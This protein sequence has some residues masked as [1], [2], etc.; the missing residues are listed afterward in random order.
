MNLNFTSGSSID[1]TFA[2]GQLLLTGT[3]TQD[4]HVVN[5]AYVDAYVNGLDFK[6]SVRVATT[7]NITLENEQT[8]DGVSVVAGDRVLVKDQ[9]SGSQ[10]G[11]Y[12]V[13]DGG[14]W[15]RATD[16]DENTEV[17]AGMY[18]YV[19][20]GTANSGKAYVL[21]TTGAI[22]LGTTALTFQLFP[23]VVT[24]SAG[25]GLT[26]VGD[27]LDVNYDDVTINLTGNDLQVKDGGINQ[28]KI[29]SSALGNGL[30]GGSGTAIAVLA[31]PTAANISI[32]GTG[33]KLAVLSDNHFFYSDG[34]NMVSVNYT[35]FKKV[36]D[37]TDV[38]NEYVDV[39][40]E[41]KANSNAEV[42]VFL[43]GVL[44]EE[45][46]SADY[47]IEVDGNTDLKR[48]AFNS[49]LG[50]EDGDKVRVR[51]IALAA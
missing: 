43:N 32:T 24:I 29:N 1:V 22:V 18:T 11:I 37:S 16:A 28:H 51:Y 3:P 34:T 47:E 14:A 45:G 13:V 39:T 21:S 10:N 42:M 27:T 4:T 49:S 23:A 36:L 31:D 35:N 44:L 38:S 2:A 5:K 15:T 6:S 25:D 33:A 30:T 19:E 48:I 20:S 8:I 46:A 17:S 7:A 12:I 26:K 40:T 41:I 9:S 50:I